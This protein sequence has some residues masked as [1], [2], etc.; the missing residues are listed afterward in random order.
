MQNM[1]SSLILILLLCFARPLLAGDK[2]L[3]DFLKQQARDK[4]LANVLK[5]Q[6]ENELA[7]VLKKKAG[8]VDLANYKEWK[9]KRPAF[10]DYEKWQAQRLSV[11]DYEKWQKKKLSFFDYEEWKAVIIYL[12]AQQT[13]FNQQDFNKRLAEQHID[14]KVKNATAHKA[15][16]VAIHERAKNVLTN[17]LAQENIYIKNKEDLLIKTITSGIDPQYAFLLIKKGAAVDCYIPRHDYNDGSYV[18]GA[19]HM[20]PLHIA[21]VERKK[22]M[23]EILLDHKANVDNVNSR[24]NTSLHLAVQTINLVICK[25][26]IAANANKTI[27]NVE[28]Q[29]PLD[30]AQN[31]LAQR[32]W[33][34]TIFWD[35]QTKQDLNNIIE[36]LTP[37][38]PP[39]PP[40]IFQTFLAS[41]ER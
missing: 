31:R 10:A 29:T 23:V 3:A 26:L 9:R 35:K 38:A 15:I 4:E 6:A 17:L 11:K 13:P 32:T 1:T 40:S 20:T 41:F 21:T 37:P 28:G 16:C 39:A 25:T 7:V 12:A 30:M 19:D 34:E 18:Y 5:Q 24:G 36:L 27:K 33:L 22:N 2:E 14:I 8:I